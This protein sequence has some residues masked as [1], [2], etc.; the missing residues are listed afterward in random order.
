MSIDYG[1]CEEMERLAIK[2]VKKWLR[3]FSW[4]AGI[5]DAMLRMDEEQKHANHVGNK[6]RELEMQYASNSLRY[7]LNRGFK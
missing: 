3:R 6:I 1:H 5:E 2:A 4:Q 7:L